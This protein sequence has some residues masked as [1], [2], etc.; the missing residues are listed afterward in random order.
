MSKNGSKSIQDPRGF[1]ETALEADPI[2]TIVNI[3]LGVRICGSSRVH[4]LH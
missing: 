3:V 2:S 4:D 1:M